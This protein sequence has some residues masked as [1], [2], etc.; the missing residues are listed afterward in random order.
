MKPP[1]KNM[2]SKVQ[3]DVEPPLKN[4]LKNQLVA[5]FWKGKPTQLAIRLRRPALPPV[6]LEDEG[7]AAGNKMWQMYL[8][9]DRKMAILL[10]I[11]YISDIYCRIP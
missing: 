9:E 3:F 6:A 10:L 7:L 4:H 11:L 1:K 5:K 8:G 2:Y